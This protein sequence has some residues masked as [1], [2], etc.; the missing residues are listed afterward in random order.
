MTADSAIRA[1]LVEA[2][3]A[4]PV[5]SAKAYMPGQVNGHTA[6]VSRER[7][8]FDSTMA[9]GSDDFRYTV[10]VLVPNTLPEVAQ[11]EMSNYLDTA[12]AYS[13]KAAVEL[14]KTL[15]GVVDFAHVSEAGPE[16]VVSVGE[17][18]YLAVD[19]TVEVTA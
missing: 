10:M 4:L 19:F 6:V 8:S 14:D 13:I 5:L 18:D 12:S 7:T 3:D 11:T 9:R 15:G 2:L 17:I 1:G 16:R